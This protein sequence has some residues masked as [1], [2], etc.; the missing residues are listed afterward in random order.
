MGDDEVAFDT[1]TNRKKM[2]QYP[3]PEQIEPEIHEAIANPQIWVV[4]SSTEGFRQ[5]IQAQPVFRE[6]FLSR[7]NNASQAYQI[8]Q[9]PAFN[10][11]EL[12]HGGPIWGYLFMGILF[13]RR[14][15]D[16][17]YEEPTE[18]TAQRV[19]IKRLDLSVVN[20][21][22][23]NGS[24]ENPFKEIYRMQTIGDDIHV[25]GMIEALQDE[26]YLY[27]ITPWCQGGCLSSNIPLV[28]NDQYSVEGQARILFQ[29]ILE[30]LHY[31]NNVHELCHRDIKPANFL[32]S[33]NG[34]I[35]ISDLAMSFKMPDGGYVKDI[36]QFG[37]PPYMPPEIALSQPFDG[38]KCDLWAA[39]VSLY[40]MVTGLPYLYRTPRPDDLLFRYTIMARGLSR[41]KHNE[42]VQEIL[43]DVNNNNEAQMIKTVA[44][45]ITNLSTD[46]LELFENSLTLNPDHRWGS[47][48]AARSTWMRTGSFL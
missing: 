2:P 32:V 47:Q 13:R 27:I 22:L 9:P 19:A 3:P 28:P 21:E 36:G 26:N 43:N 15:E 41:D 17:L 8:I 1:N 45:R 16:L 14:P 31:V 30:N 18:Q 6:V 25:L 7:R 39:I 29:Q 11:V 44:Q 42:L 20:M 40:S 24:R 35:L 48:E 10:P 34:R 12:S 38:A 23:Q 37:T 4:P 46:I 33:S 5:R